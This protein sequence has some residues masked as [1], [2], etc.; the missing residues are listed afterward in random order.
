MTFK[1]NLMIGPATGNCTFGDVL[2]HSGSFATAAY[3]AASRILYY[4]FI[5]HE[6]T[7]LARAGTYVTTGAAG[8]ANFGVYSEAGL[9]L[10]QTGNVSVAG[11]AV[12]AAASLSLVLSAGTR[13]YMA[14][15]TDVT[16]T[17]SNWPHVANITEAGDMMGCYQEAGATTVL[18]AT[19]TFA[20]WA[21]SGIFNFFLSTSATVPL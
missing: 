11:S 4:P 8:N 9:R 6:L 17:L 18:P 19:A 14:M 5:V 16:P 3:P 7:T 10:A 21:T 15:I 1:T 20:E 12:I 13:Y 2:N